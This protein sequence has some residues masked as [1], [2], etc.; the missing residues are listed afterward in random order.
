[1]FVSQQNPIIKVQPFQKAFAVHWLMTKRCNFDCS[2]CPDIYHDRS[3]KDHS[4][5]QLQQAWLK[6][7]DST[8]HIDSVRYA[9]SL[10]GGE[11]T[12]NP[13]FMPFLKWL[14]QEFSKQIVELGVITNGSA[15]EAIYLE[16]VGFCDWITFSTHSEFMSEKKFFRN[17]LA[18]HKAAGSKCLIAVNIM[19]EPW[20][21]ERNLDYKNFL[22]KHGI[23]YYLHPILDFGDNRNPLPARQVQRINFYDKV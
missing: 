6:I 1:M 21:Q 7:V 12:L 11:P 4:L 17:V 5:A 10:L 2:Y 13:D 23:Q 9:V 3:A 16:M 22:D 15:N 20:H 18:T 8:K 19:E 14:K